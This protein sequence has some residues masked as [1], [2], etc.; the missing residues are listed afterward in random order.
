LQLW[1]WTWRSQRT[2]KHKF[3]AQRKKAKGNKGKSTSTSESLEAAKSAYKKAKQDEDAPKLAITTQWAKAFKL[4]WNLLSDKVR[5]P[6]EI[7]QVQTTKCPWEDIYRVTH[8]K[9]PTKTWDSFLECITYLQHAF[10]QDS[11]KALKY[12][13]INTL[14][15]PIGFQFINFW[16]NLS[17]IIATSKLYDACTL[18]QVQIRLQSK[19]CP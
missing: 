13:I 5:Q 12:Y 8:D 2:S 3:S 17:S 16:C 19:Y 18:A 1:C 11:G 14:G 15:K 6:W 10:R 9:T 7:L 4:Y